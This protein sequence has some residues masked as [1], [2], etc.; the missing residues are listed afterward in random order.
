M[1]L[2]LANH[3]GE[4]QGCTYLK[5]KQIPTESCWLSWKYKGVNGILLR[6][7]EAEIKGL[8]LLSSVIKLMANVHP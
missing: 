7:G 3:G 1:F 2:S 4:K 5:R 8:E 6:R